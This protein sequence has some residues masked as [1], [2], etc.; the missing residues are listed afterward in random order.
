MRSG[1]LGGD[2]DRRRLLGGGDGSYGSVAK[3][4]SDGDGFMKNGS[5]SSGIDGPMKNGSVGGGDGGDGGGGGGGGAGGGSCNDGFLKP[6]K[7][8]SFAGDEEAEGGAEG[9]G[10]EAD[11]FHLPHCGSASA[12]HNNAAGILSTANGWQH[13]RP[14]PRSPSCR[15][16]PAQRSHRRGESGNGGVMSGVLLAPKD[17]ATGG[18]GEGSSLAAGGR[19]GVEFD[20]DAEVEEEGE[21]EEEEEEE[22]MPSFIVLDC[23]KVTNVSAGDLFLAV[24]W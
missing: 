16:S 3:G 4:G 14:P 24:G 7:S 2:E 10:A 11:R 8:V 6:T 22:E 18:E 23:S 15:L 9:G 17:S 1:S 5:G 19:G 12:H 21:D 20:V 13:Q